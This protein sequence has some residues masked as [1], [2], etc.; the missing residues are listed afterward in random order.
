MRTPRDWLMCG[1]VSL[2]IIIGGAL[3]GAG[4][5]YDEPARARLPAPTFAAIATWTPG[6][7]QTAYPLTFREDGALYVASMPTPT[8]T[9]LPTET[10]IP[11][12]PPTSPGYCVWPEPASAPAIA[13]AIPTCSATPHPGMGCM[14]REGN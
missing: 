12:C 8:W 3:A 5:S 9:P 4:M 6:P 13:T 2:A 14:W 11:S 1:L 7:E 10:P